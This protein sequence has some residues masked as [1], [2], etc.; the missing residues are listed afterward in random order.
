MYLRLLKRFV[1]IGEVVPYDDR[2][3]V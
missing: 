1:E 3:E 2:L